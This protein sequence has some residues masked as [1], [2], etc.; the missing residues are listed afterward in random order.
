MS[1]RKSLDDHV[2]HLRSVLES[3]RREK[4]YANLK[5]CSFC[6][7]R[8]VFLGFVVSSRGVEVD[9]KKVRAIKD[10]PTPTTI[11]EV[12]S[13]HGLAGFYRRFVP[14]F[15]TVAA[16]LTEIIKKD[17]GFKWEEEQEKAFNTLKEKLSSAPLLLIPDISKPFEIECD[18]S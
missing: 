5:K 11:A 13:F 9:E 10:W 3:L 18:A 8:V 15:S 16:S 17:V 2:E 12:R 14:N 1:G 4:L 7:D 6:L